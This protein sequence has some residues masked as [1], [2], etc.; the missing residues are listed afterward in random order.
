MYKCL[1]WLTVFS[2]ILINHTLLK[3]QNFRNSLPLIH[4]LRY[5]DYL[6][7]KW[8]LVAAGF[9]ILGW[10][11]FNQ[12]N[13]F[14]YLK[15]NLLPILIIL[16]VLLICRSIS[17]QRWFE[18]DDYRL[19]GHQHAVNG[20]A[21]YNQMGLINNPFYGYAASYAVVNLLDDKFELYNSL[22]IFIL[23]LIGVVVFTIANKLQKRRLVSLLAA[24]FFVTSPTYWRQILQMHEFLGDTFP[25]LLST[26]SVYLLVVRFYPGAIIFA[27]A[28]LE[29]GLSREHFIALPLILI[30]LFFVWSKKIPKEELIITLATLPIL[31]M[32]Y[33]PVLSSHP[34]E[35][36]NKNDWLSNWPQLIRI[37]DSIFAASMPHGVAS[38]L[39]F[40]PRMLMPN[41]F[42]ISSLLGV[43][44]VVSL[45]I[46][47]IWSFNRRKILAA[48]I[49]TVGLVIVTVSMVFPTLMGIRLVH[50]FKILPEQY[51]DFF[52][53]APTSYG[54]PAAFG[55]AFLVIG[56]GQ[57]VRLKIFNIFLISLITINIVT[58]LAADYEWVKQFS[59][60]QRIANQQL[61][62]II[63]ADGQTKVIYAEKILP[64]YISYFYQLYRIKEPLYVSNDPE[65]FIRLIKK[66]QPKKEG[67]YLLVLDDKN[68]TIYDNSQKLRVYEVQKL[69]AKLLE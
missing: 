39:L 11:L 13:I 29:F 64:R 54:L 55:L 21:N 37:S 36:L 49:L 40:L 43:L 6:I 32:L 68:Y 20:T 56:F 30:G 4:N 38:F 33:L 27:A 2:S 59:R 42:Y 12:R 22:G 66:Y 60:P 41:N 51:S 63:S 23:F 14:K 52:P 47:I 26:L 34:P 61:E 69:T 53:A 62:N 18:F 15:I 67:I 45:I 50:D 31:S 8:F 35:I 10:W 46:L 16:I 44:I 25:L 57:L 24:L 3:D 19:I 28:A 58:V 17:F 9:I 5:S 48:K 65:E 1:V 7:Q